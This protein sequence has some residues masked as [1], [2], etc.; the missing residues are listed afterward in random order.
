MEAGK[1]N[2]RVE[3]Q[4]LVETQDAVTGEITES[5]S[6]FATPWANIRFLSGREFVAAAAEQN[7]VTATVV[8]YYRD[9]VDPKM[10]IVHGSRIFNILEVLPDPM[11]GREF[12]TLPVREVRE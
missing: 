12:L 3:I 6:T 10:R 5:W 4:Q 9:G 11:S 7:E 2:H 8:I 1:L